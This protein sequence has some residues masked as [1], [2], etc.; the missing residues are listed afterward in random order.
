MSDK[1]E[2]IHVGER[3]SYNQKCLYILHTP[4]HYDCI[5]TINQFFETDYFC[6]FCKKKYSLGRHYCQ[7]SCVCCQR[8]KCI[9]LTGPKED[10]SKKCK[11]CDVNFMVD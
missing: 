2:I 9:K 11:Y 8:H 5:K 3:V 7:K 6:E 4:K 1:V 10:D